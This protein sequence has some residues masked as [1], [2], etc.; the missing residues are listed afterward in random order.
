MHS[1]DVTLD[2]FNSSKTSVRAIAWNELD[3]INFA[4]V[5]LENF[6]CSEK[7]NFQRLTLA[8]T[9]SNI[10]KLFPPQNYWPE[11]SFRPKILRTAWINFQ[12]FSEY[13]QLH[14]VHSM[15]FIPWSTVY[16]TG[17]SPG[18]LASSW[19]FMNSNNAIAWNILVESDHVTSCIAHNK[20]SPNKPLFSEGKTFCNKRQVSL[21]CCCCSRAYL[22]SEILI[23]FAEKLPAR[24]SRRTRLVWTLLIILNIFSKIMKFS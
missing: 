20:S 22:T 4:R 24:N 17:E 3:E 12:L 14:E 21:R 13:R 7:S 5:Q 6:K 11:S 2:E 1:S 16:T 9:L 8:W 10:S 15:N 19:M 23:N 18:E